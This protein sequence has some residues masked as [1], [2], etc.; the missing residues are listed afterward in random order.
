MPEYLSEININYLKLIN[1][2]TD[3]N[4]EGS[5]PGILRTTALP[6]RVYT[7]WFIVTFILLL[8]I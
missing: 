1:L 7:K 5:I 3:I 4:Y 6:D 2:K 8:K